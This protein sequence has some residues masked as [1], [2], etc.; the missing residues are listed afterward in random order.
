VAVV[1]WFGLRRVPLEKLAEAHLRRKWRGWPSIMNNDRWPC[2]KAKAH[3]KSY[4]KFSPTKAVQNAVRS[5]KT[6]LLPSV[7]T[8][9]SLR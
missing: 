6:C 5:A 3:A 8:P 4:S 9:L 1:V 7:R 2:A